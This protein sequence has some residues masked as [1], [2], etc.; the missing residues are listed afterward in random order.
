EYCLLQRH[1][2]FRIWAIFRLKR[3]PPVSIPNVSPGST[4]KG[5]CGATSVTFLIGVH[6]PFDFCRKSAHEMPDDCAAE[7][8]ADAAWAAPGIADRIRLAV[9]TAYPI[10]I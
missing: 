7:G 9:R 2:S 5:P 8:C 4:V 3:L 1:R 6:E 10:F